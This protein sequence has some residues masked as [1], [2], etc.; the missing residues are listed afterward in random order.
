MPD[1][2]YMRKSLIEDDLAHVIECIE[3][4]DLIESNYDDRPHL[5]MTVENS[6]GNK[7]LYKKNGNYR[8]VSINFKNGGGSKV[9]IGSNFKG[10]LKVEVLAPNCLLYIGDNVR[11]NGVRIRFIGNSSRIF[12]GSGVTAT[13]N[14]SWVNGFMHGDRQDLIV[15]DDCMFSWGITLRNTDAHPIYDTN[16]WMPINSPKQ[17]LI[18]EPHCW[19]GQSVSVLKNVKIGAC[20]IVAL[21]SVVTKSAPRFSAISGVPAQVRSIEGRLWSRGGEYAMRS[22]LKYL[23]RFAEPGTYSSCVLNTSAAESDELFDD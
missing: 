8:N 19:I 16:T 9:Y 4:L 15:G 6:I 22:A 13:S 14:N 23:H 1:D 17:P 20:S 18:I 5:A 2:S 21:G 3:G 10:S 7:V 12:V 11:L